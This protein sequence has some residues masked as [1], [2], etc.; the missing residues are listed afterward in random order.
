MRTMR[1]VATGLALALGMVA[2]AARLEAQATEMPFT[3]IVN[4]NNP[5]S[6]F[7]REELSRMFLKKVTVWRTKRPVMPVDLKE[8]VR[9]GR[10]R[11]GGDLDGAQLHE[12]PAQDDREVH[13]ASDDG[14]AARPGSDADARE[15]QGVAPGGQRREAEAAVLSGDVPPPD[16]GDDDAHSGQGRGRNVHQR[17]GD[18]ETEIMCALKHSLVQT[19]REVSGA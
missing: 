9:T 10:R 1:T 13:V 11:R 8:G 6:Q 7:T 19:K 18:R 4:E 16:F 5:A 15:G 17:H 12:R 3:V 2:G 14:H